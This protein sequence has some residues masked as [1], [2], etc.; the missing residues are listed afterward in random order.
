MKKLDI[1]AIITG[2]SS[3]IFCLLFFVLFLATGAKA[4]KDDGGPGKI[5]AFFG[6]VKE[7]IVE[8]TGNDDYVNYKDD[9]NS[10]RIGP[11]G[12]FVTTGD[13]EVVVS[14]TG[15]HVSEAQDEAED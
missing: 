3:I 12:V 1:V 10:V 9:N 11:D 14:P 8:V 4:F 7:R 15:V 13:E 5:K 2:V 6:S